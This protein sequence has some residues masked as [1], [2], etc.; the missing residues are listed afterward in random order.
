M[1]LDFALA[2]GWISILHSISRFNFEGNICPRIRNESKKDINSP[3][4]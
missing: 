4:K 2:Y 3:S 1:N